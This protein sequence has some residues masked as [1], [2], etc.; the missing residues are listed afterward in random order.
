[1]AAL[2]GTL[3]RA[4]GSLTPAHAFAAAA[5]TKGARRQLHSKGN[6]SALERQ[7][8]YLQ[9]EAADASASGRMKLVAAAQQQH[10]TALAGLRRAEALAEA[11]VCDASREAEALQAVKAALQGRAT[12]LDRNL[13]VLAS[14]LAAAR[15]EQTEAGQVAGAA[16][17][18][19]GG[20]H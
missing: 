7:E 19:G 5:A 18:L 20:G 4:E 1:L 2:Q 17:A 16:R 11:R 8:L 9:L 12:S 14:K 10:D 6:S 15:Q 13:Q 3:E